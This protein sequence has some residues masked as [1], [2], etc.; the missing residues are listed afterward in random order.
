MLGSPSPL[1]V[2]GSFLERPV[3]NKR[4]LLGRSAI[5]LARPVHVDLSPKLTFG[6]L[7]DIKL[8]PQSACTYLVLSTPITLPQYNQRFKR[9]KRFVSVTIDVYIVESKSFAHGKEICRNIYNVFVV[10]S[11]MVSYTGMGLSTNDISCFSW[12]I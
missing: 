3:L 12:P 8:K 6:E 5:T 4:N 2:K 9:I 1:E 10:L 11:E 7:S